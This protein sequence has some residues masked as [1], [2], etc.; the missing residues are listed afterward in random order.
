MYASSIHFD[1]T[2][3]SITPSYVVNLVRVSPQNKQLSNV[4]Y[5]TLQRRR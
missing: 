2:E 5:V 1:P 3:S 4:K